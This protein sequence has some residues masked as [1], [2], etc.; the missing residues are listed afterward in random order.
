MCAGALVNA[1]LPR[2]V[3][4]CRDPKAG[5]VDS[6]YQL[7]SDPRLNHRIEICEGVLGEESAVL[8]R[9]FFSARRKNKLSGSGPSPLPAE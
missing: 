1:R 5:A 7:C 3:Y 8:L 2:L 9:T 4:G 6:L